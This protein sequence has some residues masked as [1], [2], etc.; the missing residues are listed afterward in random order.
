DGFFQGDPEPADNGMGNK[1]QRAFRFL[2]LD[3]MQPR[4]HRWRFN[5]VTGGVREEQLTDSITEFGMINSGYAASE[6]RYA[7]AATGKPAW[8]L[9]DGLVKHDL[10]TG[11]EER[12][13]F[14][15]GVYGSE[16]AMAPRWNGASEDDGYLITITTDMNDDASYC[17]VFDA[18]RVTDGPVCKL[19]LPERVSSG[20]HST[21]APGSELRRWRETDSAAEAIGL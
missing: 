4:L 16:T 14:D 21:W 12:F 20:T 10:L 7:Y 13:A 18:A 11:A 5:L 15:D 2:A 1:W 8:F 3:R 17:L 9:F 6:Y 19:A